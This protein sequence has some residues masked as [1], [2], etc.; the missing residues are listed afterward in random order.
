M[1]Q[2][3]P[4]FTAAW[5]DIDNTGLL[6]TPS[7]PHQVSEEAQSRWNP[8]LAPTYVFQEPDANTI[9]ATE[10]PPILPVD[11]F[12]SSNFADIMVTQNI[13]NSQ[14]F[15]FEPAIFNI[16]SPTCKPVPTGLDT[17]LQKL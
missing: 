10:A 13:L 9:S 8:V 2:I 14:P 15:E 3:Q 11:D 7:P 4:Q 6:I 16:P 5:R 17:A 12:T 1:Q